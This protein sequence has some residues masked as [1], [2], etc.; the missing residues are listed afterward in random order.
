M[1]MEPDT[2]MPLSGSP[3]EIAAS[4]RDFAQQGITHLQV[5]LVPNT[6]ETIE[7]FGKVLEELDR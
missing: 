3:Q 1:S 5:A 6:I 7:I 4:I 2:A